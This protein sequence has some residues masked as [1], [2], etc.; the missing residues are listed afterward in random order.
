MKEKECEHVFEWEE[1]EK[2]NSKGLPVEIKVWCKKC[3]M[4]R[5]LGFG[6]VIPK[7][8][9]KPEPKPE[10][11]KYLHP[12][13]DLEDDFPWSKL[14]MI[15]IIEK[16]KNCKHETWY[17]CDE[18]NDKEYCESWLWHLMP[19]QERFKCYDCGI[20]VQ[21]IPDEEVNIGYNELPEPEWIYRIACDLD[22][23]FP[24]SKL[25]LPDRIEKQKNCKHEV[26]YECGEENDET[27]FLDKIYR[28]VR[29]WEYFRCHECGLPVHFFKG[30]QNEAEFE[31]IHEFVKKINFKIKYPYWVQGEIIPEFREFMG[32]E[33]ENKK[34]K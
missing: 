10:P 9:P 6:E 28:S 24:W 5:V 1:S 16:Q 4:K 23:D 11:G 22:R 31:K 34:Q 26:W 30:K 7:P 12:A 8:K 21:F 25:S 20:M 14:G 32:I 2:R 13:L 29:D 33:K 19:Y 15:E 17:E 27:Y 18:T 3:G